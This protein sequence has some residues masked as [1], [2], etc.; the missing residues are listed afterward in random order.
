MLHIQ[1]RKDFDLISP[2]GGIGLMSLPCFGQWS[3]RLSDVLLLLA[4][5]LNGHLLY[6]LTGHWQCTG[7]RSHTIASACRCARNQSHQ[8]PALA[9]ALA[10][11]D[12]LKWGSFR[13]PE[14]K[15][16]SRLDVERWRRKSEDNVPV[17]RSKFFILFSSSPET[18]DRLGFG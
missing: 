5:H 13:K 15:T 17:S 7:I 1:V 2:L 3:I 10:L 12:W 6:T 11:V 9:H 16:Y 14:G 8:T 18:L 4:W